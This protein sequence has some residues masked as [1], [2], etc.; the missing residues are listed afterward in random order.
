MFMQIMNFLADSQ[1]LPTIV[2]VALILA[3]VGQVIFMSRAVGD[4]RVAVPGVGMFL[5]G[6]I[7]AVAHP[8]M[9]AI[10]MLAHEL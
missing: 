10:S 9:W 2:G 4:P 7:I 6:F 8:M 1:P 5:I 3:G